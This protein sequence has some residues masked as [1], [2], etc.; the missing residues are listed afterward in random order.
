M[1][2]PPV[3]SI[4]LGYAVGAYGLWGLIPLYFKAVVEVVPLEVL[5]HRLLWSCAL[6]GVVLLISQ[7][8]SQLRIAFSTWRTISL[9]TISTL[10]IGVNW[11][12]FIHAVSNGQVLQ[13][14]LGYFVTPLAN[15]LLG[16]LFLGERL[17]WLQWFS[18]GLAAIALVAPIWLL[19][20][21]PSVALTLAVTFSLYG[22]LKKIIPVGGL[23]SLAVETLLLA[24]LALGYLVVLNH[25]GL[26]TATTGH[27]QMVLALSGLVTTVPLLLFAAAARRL[28]M[29]TLGIVQ[30]LTPSLQIV[31]A[32]VIFG[33]T[34]T[35]ERITS[36]VIIWLAIGLC[37]FALFRERHSMKLAIDDGIVGD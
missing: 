29:K 17:R 3:N 26:S 4:G 24:P 12:T 18:F 32:V 15:V 30:Y 20:Q 34:L 27:L 21:F 28:E 5:A 19:G 22:L 33:E 8:Q 6:L 37:L 23:V 13:S 14:S 9:L 7:P 25:E 1:H 31:V 2:K 10:L 16:V 35:I 11:L 36:F